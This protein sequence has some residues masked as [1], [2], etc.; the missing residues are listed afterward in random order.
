MIPHVLPLLRRIPPGQ[1]S[2]Y[3]D[4]ARFFGVP[5]NA[6]QMGQILGSNEHP[7]VYP[8]YKVV[9]SDGALTGYSAYRGLSAKQEM[10]EEE[11]I[12]VRGSRDIG[13]RETGDKGKGLRVEGLEQVRWRPKFHSYF[14]AIPLDET[15]RNTF[16]RAYNKAT[17][18]SADGKLLNFQQRE[19]PH[20][21]LHFF[22]DLSLE[23]LAHIVK[24]LK[25]WEVQLKVQSRKSKVEKGKMVSME[26][27]GLDFFGPAGNREVGYFKAA[28]GQEACA[29]LQKELVKTL[30]VR[31][32]SPFEPHLTFFRVKDAQGLRKAE[33]TIAAALR[34]FEFEVNVDTVRLYG[35][36]DQA[37]QVPLIDFHLGA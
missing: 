3:G 20:V 17:R 25:D 4:F 29:T 15:N 18:L 10:L 5:N 14:L 31:E 34:E 24:K 12:R 13:V 9:A 36:V 30:G 33:Q 6:R 7:E 23:K 2:T 19:T 21:T 32:E 8:C 26:F 1:L 28:A 11:G 27:K 35:A 22:G 37:N 16:E